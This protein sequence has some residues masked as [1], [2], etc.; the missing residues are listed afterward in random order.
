MNTSQF[1]KL[2]FEPEVV[3]VQQQETQHDNA[4]HE[5]V[6]ALPVHTF[7]T[8]TDSITV[9]AAGTVVLDSQHDGITEVY[10]HTQCQHA[11][12]GYCVPVSAQHS[13]NPVICLRSEQIVNHQT[14]VHRT[15]EQQEQNKEQAGYTHNEFTADR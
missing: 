15:V 5:H 12:A 7:L 9:V 13:A 1:G 10:E 3:Q 8:C 4:E 2:H 11:C 14:Q 6:L